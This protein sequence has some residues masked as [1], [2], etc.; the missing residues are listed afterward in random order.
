M[1]LTE[2]TTTFNLHDYFGNDFDPRRAKAWATNNADGMKI[3]DTSTGET[4]IGAGVA[5]IA[6]DGT[7]TFAHWAPGADGNPVSWQTTYHF[8]VPD[9][10]E[11]RGRRTKSFGPYTVT[12]SGLLTA[13]EDEQAVPPTYLTTVTELLDGYVT[14]AEAARDA[15]VDISNIAIDDD[16]VEAL[17][18]GTAG[19][20][21]KTRAELAATYVRFVRSDTGAP[22]PT[23]KVKITVDPT[24]H[25]IV[26]IIWEA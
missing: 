6:A 22:M 25:D 3:D 15:T 18:K 21:P 8:D 20:G 17:L 24:T 14:D 9:R 1:A 10:T 26:D 13:L 7:G 5:V 12:A 19:A 4:R 11:P 16:I 23:G 2:I